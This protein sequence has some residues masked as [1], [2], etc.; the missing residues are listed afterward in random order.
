MKP[1]LL[2]HMAN[3]H[4]SV[5]GRATSPYDAHGFTRKL[6]ERLDAVCVYDIS[7]ERIHTYTIRNIRLREMSDAHHNR[8]EHVFGNFASRG[9][10]GDHSPSASG[11]VVTSPPDT[12]H[13]LVIPDV[14]EKIKLLP[15]AGEHLHDVR[16]SHVV[17][18]G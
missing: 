13:L 6:L 12:C 17:R 9:V 5:Q 8:I 3:F 18:K 11:T 15:V 2:G 4:C 1:Y 10:S 16:V 7:S 14:S